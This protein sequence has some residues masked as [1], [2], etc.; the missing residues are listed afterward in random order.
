MK[1]ILLA[2]LFFSTSLLRSQC[3]YSCS[4]YS[5]SPR[6]YSFMEVGGTQ[7]FLPDDDVSTTV[8]IN[9]NFDFYCTTYNQVRIASNGFITFDF[10]P[11][12]L[13]LTPYA[14][15]VPNVA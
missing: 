12:T 7:V 10:G 13:S 9:F 3:T 1:G 15:K 8:P 5:V 6:T 2:V 4:S 11:I 14:Q